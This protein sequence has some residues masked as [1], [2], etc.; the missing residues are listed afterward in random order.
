MMRPTILERLRRGCHTPEPPFP[1]SNVPKVLIEVFHTLV[2]ERNHSWV[3]DTN[4]LSY[5][6]KNTHAPR[7]VRWK[8][9]ISRDRGSHDQLRGAT[10]L[11]EIEVDSVESPTLVCI[12]NNA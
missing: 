8:T 12:T 9:G 11:C 3:S 6:T 1:S 5:Q 7:S 10:V 2:G 4:G